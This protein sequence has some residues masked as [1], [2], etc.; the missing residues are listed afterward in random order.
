LRG[1]KQSN[2]ADRQT[3]ARHNT[4]PAPSQ[5]GKVTSTFQACHDRRAQRPGKPVSVYNDKNQMNHS[6]NK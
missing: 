4:P 2:P 6:S 1:M 3:I 5:E